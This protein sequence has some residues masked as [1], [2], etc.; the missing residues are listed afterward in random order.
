MGVMNREGMK[1]TLYV[2]RWIR[3]DDSGIGVF[4]ES[5]GS[6]IWQRPQIPAREIY[7]GMGFRYPKFHK[8]DPPCQWAYLASEWLLSGPESPLNAGIPMDRVALV[9]GSRS[10]CL[11][12][13]LSFYQSMEMVPSPAL[14]VYTLPNIMMGEI[15][16]R[17]GFKG[18]QLCL[19]DESLPL[20]LARH[21]VEDLLYYRGMEAC[22]LG[23][24]E[25]FGERKKIGLFW[26]SHHPSPW[27]F[28]D[29]LIQKIFP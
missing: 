26:V 8:M 6:P 14:F 18:E 2:N 12:T 5:L 10:G 19:I 20:P 23:W 13:D 25:V 9:M 7:E 21:Y 27:E 22:L 29:A 3:V 15:C 24:V 17:H 16:I 4:P 1:R 28:G 11:E